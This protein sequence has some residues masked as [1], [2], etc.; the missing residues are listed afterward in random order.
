MDHRLM[1]TPEEATRVRIAMVKYLERTLDRHIA[2]NGG[3]DGQIFSAVLEAL[4]RHVP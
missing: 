3:E 2:F 1:M 4:T